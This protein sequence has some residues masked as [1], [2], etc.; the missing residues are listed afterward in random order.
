MSI[1]RFDAIDSAIH[2]PSIDVKLPSTKISDY[3]ASNVFNTDTM[4]K[5][6]SQN[7]FISVMEA[8][9]TNQKISSELADQVAAA[10]KEWGISKGA[11][12]YTHW[13]QPLTGSTAEKHDTFFTPTDDSKGI[14]KFS[15]NALVQQEPDGSSFPSGGLRATFE[16]RG[17][18]AWDPSSPAFIMQVG[19]SAKTL[20]IPTIFIAYTGEALDYKVPLLRSQQLLNRAAL[21]VAQ[22]FN[23]DVSKVVPTLGWEQEYFLVDSA[24][25][26]SRPDLMATGRTVL[27][28]APP[29]GQQLDD[30]Y[31]GSISERVHAFML[32]FETEALKLGITISTRHNEVAPSQYECAPVF[33]DGNTAVDKNQLVMDVMDRV[34]KRHN[35]ELLLHEKPYAGVNG[36]GKHNNW[37]MATDTGINLLS[38]GGTPQKNLRFLTFFINTIKALHSNDNLLRGSIA[39]AGN[40]HRL[41]ANEAPPAIISAFIGSTLTKILEAV[42]AQQD[43]SVDST[44]ASLDVVA[45]IPNVLMDNTDR[46][47]TSP[48]A[49]TGNKFEFRAVGSSSSCAP[50]MIALN[51]IVAHQLLKF[52]NEVDA[53]LTS[54]E[55]KETAI[56]SILRRYIGESKSILFEGDNYTQE[57]ADEAA[58]R[59]LANVKKTPPALDFLADEAAKEVLVGNKIYSEQELKA[60]HEV[61]LHNYLTKIDIESKV[62]EEMV[63]SQIIPATI[64][65]QNE[66]IP[67]FLGLKEAGLSRKTL[68][69]QKKLLEQLQKHLI[70]LKAG[71]DKMVKGRTKAHKAANIRAEA[72][73]YCDNVAS[74]FDEIRKHADK[75]ETLIDNKIWPLPKYRE[76]LF[77]K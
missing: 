77:I 39:S 63:L 55:D 7:A 36:S 59:G 2:R 76:L 29:K 75:L 67:N 20:C 26:Y 5:Y 22:L 10:M 41:G 69:P 16:A 61:M 54:G 58:R 13:F 47:R 9:R 3:F 72:I 38:P 4:R 12:S 49:F 32:D 62:M 8:I 27:G 23:E 65:Y 53:R 71:L 33:S 24:L 37:S 31:F 57:W 25:Y 28:A 64:E 30:H 11:T 15:G 14:E 21:P 68:A 45:N 18:T 42:E 73:A 51:S 46:N 48:F 52:N 44:K 74:C 50:P 70:G 56:L 19:S 17:Y 35:L 6:L 34:A 43:D 60:Y 1:N 66:L 40:D